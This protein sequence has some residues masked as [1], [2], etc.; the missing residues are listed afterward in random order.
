MEKKGKPSLIKSQNPDLKNLDR[1]LQSEDG[2]KALKDGL[3][4]D[5]ALDISLGDEKIFI[6]SLQQA[7]SALQKAFGTLPTGYVNEDPD[8][9]KLAITI[10]GLAN[11]LVDA[12]RIRRQRNIREAAVSNNE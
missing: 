7:K 12:M 5:V 11:E 8:A 2:V 10:E 4:L 3:P 6:Q 1:V 9:L